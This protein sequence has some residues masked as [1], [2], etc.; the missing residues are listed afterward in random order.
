MW[1]NAEMRDQYGYGRSPV[2]FVKHFWLIAVPEKGVNNAFDYPVGLPYLLVLGP[3]IFLFWNTLRRREFAVVPWIVVL[4]WFLWWEGTQ[5]SRYLYIPTVLMFI[6]VLPQ[7]KNYS[8][9]FLAA[10]L[11]ALSLNALSIF[12]A[13][14]HDLVRAPQA[15]LR[16]KDQM[17]VEMNRRYITDQSSDVVDLDFHDVAFAQFP[18][19]VIRGS[20]PHTLA[21]E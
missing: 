5:Q 10:L 14:R 20:L 2:D 17:L 7:M 18:V 16:D 6:T 12:R 15:V 19:R 3:F 21:L 1:T 8:K 11:V 13:H 9:I 4:S